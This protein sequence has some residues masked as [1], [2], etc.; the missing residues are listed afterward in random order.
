[1]TKFYEVSRSIDA[2]D[3][4]G[5]ET[6]SDC[7]I[8]AVVYDDNDECVTVV[9]GIEQT[10]PDHLPELVRA[11][12]HGFSSPIPGRSGRY[13]WADVSQIPDDYF[14]GLP[15][16]VVSSGLDS[17]AE[18]IAEISEDEFTLYDDD[19]EDAGKAL[20]SGTMLGTPYTGQQDLGAGALYDGGWRASD[21]DE[22]ADTYGLCD[23]YLDK[24]VEYLQDYE[25]KDSSDE[26]EEE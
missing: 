5:V 11:A 22:L 19:L 18:L 9:P 20:F 1:M 14:G 23:E 24:L 2:E 25:E 4:F 7:R 10:D 8:F 15:L 21:R 6:N 17:K 13:Y 12:R 26:D 16:D 3:D